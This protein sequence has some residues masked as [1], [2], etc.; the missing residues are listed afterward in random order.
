MHKAVESLSNWLRQCVQLRRFFIYPFLLE[1][2]VI[3]LW[4]IC[5][6]HAPLFLT[7]STVFL[8]MPNY[9]LKIWPHIGTWTSSVIDVP[10]KSEMYLNMQ[11]TPWP[12]QC[13]DNIHLRWVL[14]NS[15]FLFVWLS[16][17]LYGKKNLAKKPLNTKFYGLWSRKLQLL[18]P[19]R[20][21][22]GDQTKVL[23]MVL[24]FWARWEL[25]CCLLGIIC[26]CSSARN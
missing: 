9:R 23:I 13:Y 21:D 24:D 14:T 20:F 5:Q 1:S 6:D 11:P 7:R 10:T 17:D 25:L 2:E 18:S 8:N 3:S 26:H 12:T 4:M 16:E 15:C 22:I 19:N